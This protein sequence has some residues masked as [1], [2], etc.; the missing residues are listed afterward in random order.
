M[1]TIRRRNHRGNPCELR[2]DNPPVH[3][4]FM[5]GHSPI[6]LRPSRDTQSGERIP[7]PPA[8]DGDL[9]RTLTPM[10]LPWLGGCTPQPPSPLSVSVTKTAATTTA[11]FSAAAFVAA[12]FLPSLRYGDATVGVDIELHAEGDEILESLV[13]LTRM[14][15]LF[16]NSS[17][18]Y[19]PSSRP[20]PERLTPPNGSS[21][22]SAPT[23]LTNT[24]P[25]S[26]ESATR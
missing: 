12:S 6:E 2:N 14:S 7:A 5:A 13:Q 20:K 1:G 19:L 22:P 3:R 25:A 10:V 4:A 23:A 26:S 24:M 9:T 17:I 8:K 15:F 16:T 11:V 18:P 21:T